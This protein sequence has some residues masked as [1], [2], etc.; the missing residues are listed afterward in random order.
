[1][2]LIDFKVDG[3]GFIIEYNEDGVKENED[4]KY[5]IY[6]VD[7]KEKTLLICMREDEC[8]LL[9][10]LLNFGVHKKLVEIDK[11][12]VEVAKGEKDG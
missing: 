1:M 2:K 9:S 4:D 10:A 7:G 3:R 11:V 6:F 8:I 5:Y 12:G